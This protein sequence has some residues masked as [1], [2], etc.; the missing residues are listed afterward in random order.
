MQQPPR[1]PA[2]CDSDRSA[3]PAATLVS[4]GPGRTYTTPLAG[5]SPLQ[6]AGMVAEPPDMSEAG[7]RER[8]GGEAPEGRVSEATLLLRAPINPIDS[9][10]G[11]SPC[12]RTRGRHRSR[13]KEARRWWPAWLGAGRSGCRQVDI[14]CRGWQPVPR[15]AAGC[16]ALPKPSTPLRV[17]SA[18]G[19]AR[20]H[21]QLTACNPSVVERC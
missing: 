16:P 21:D 4:D 18:N 17:L 7:G 14:C 13:G 19:C 3:A 8:E 10:S 20:R 12:S 2:I 15:M 11:L 5:A 9:G 1:R 6:A